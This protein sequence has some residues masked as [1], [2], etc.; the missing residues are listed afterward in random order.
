MTKS[1]VT[2]YLKNVGKS[3]GYAFSDSLK[4]Y[5]PNM[6]KL[7]KETSEK[8]KEI[9]ESTSDFAKNNFKIEKILNQNVKDTVNDAF[10]SIKDDLSSGNFYNRDKIDNYESRIFGS[11]MGMDMDFDFIGEMI[12]ISITMTKNHMKT[13]WMRLLLLM[14]M[15]I[16]QESFRLSIWLE[17]ELVS[18]LV[19]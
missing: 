1:S 11:I 9:A 15:Q 12:L 4:S 19:E 16:Q 14:I 10:K 2:S 3:F 7:V 8:T 18:L 17:M 13:K 6:T 5:S